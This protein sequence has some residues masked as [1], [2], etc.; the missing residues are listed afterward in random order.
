MQMRFGQALDAL[1]AE[2]LFGWTWI[3]PASTLSTSTALAGQRLLAPPALV[4]ACPDVFVPAALDLPVAS[5][6]Y[7]AVPP[8][9][10]LR[11][12]FTEVASAM[13]A[14]NWH[15]IFVDTSGAHPHRAAAFVRCPAAG[16]PAGSADI[17]PYQ[18]C[19]AALRALDGDREA[20]QT[21]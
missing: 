5:T 7:D 18:G 11:S 9:S 2:A 10:A 1:V 12:A 6:A 20:G 4:H 8:Y 14:R 21:G 13:A 3:T 19:L 17:D 16:D 15:A